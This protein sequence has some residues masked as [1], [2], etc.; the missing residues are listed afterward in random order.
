[1]LPLYRFKPSEEVEIGMRI[2]LVHGDEL[3][4]DSG[5][6]GGSI[7]EACAQFKEWVRKHYFE[8]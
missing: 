7:Q 6:D 1:L 5:A 3:I 4:A 8:E 2:R